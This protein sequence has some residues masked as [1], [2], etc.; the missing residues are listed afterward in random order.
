M[1]VVFRARRGLTKLPGL[2]DAGDLSDEK[3]L[4][5]GREPMVQDLWEVDDQKYYAAYSCAEVRYFSFPHLSVCHN[6][7]VGLAY[8]VGCT[9]ALLE[10]GAAVPFRDFFR[11]SDEGLEAGP[12]ASASLAAEFAEWDDRAKMVAYEGDGQF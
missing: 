8:M 1:S 2:Q 3:V 12:E 6:W 10:A 9:E 11:W 4:I 7:I 5:V